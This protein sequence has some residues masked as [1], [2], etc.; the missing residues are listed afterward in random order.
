MNVQME[1]CIKKTLFSFW[2]FTPI[3]ENGQGSEEDSYGFCWGDIYVD[4]YSMDDPRGSRAS[5]WFPSEGHTEN[6]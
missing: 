3:A 2:L 6:E 4:L 1:G 5:L